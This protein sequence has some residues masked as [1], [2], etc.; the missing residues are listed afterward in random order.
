MLDSLPLWRTDTSYPANGDLSHPAGAE[1]TVVHRAGDDTYGFLHDS[2]IVVHK[3]VLFAAWY[4]CPSGEIVGESLIRG[5]RSVDGGRTWSDAEVIA[6]DHDREGVFY[7]PVQFLSTGDKLYAYV[8]TMTGHDVVATCEAFKLGPAGAPSDWTPCGTMAPLFLPNAGPART[9]DGTLLMAGRCAALLGELPTIP[10]VA[11]SLEPLGPWQ[12]IPLLPNGMLP[13]G[14]TL[15][16]PETTLIVNGSEV[17]AFVRNDYGYALVFTSRNSGRTWDGPFEQDMP[18]G[19]SR[20]C[21][22]V[23]STGQRYIIFNT[24]TDGYRDLLAIAVSKPGEREFSAV[25]KVAHGYSDALECGSEW[26][27]PAAVEHEGT[28]FVVYT[29]GKRHCAMATIPVASLV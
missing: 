28:L 27:Y 22:G 23:L 11:R 25:W 19:A 12:V 2:A 29:S 26:S 17:T 1:H 10:A 24:P 4:N 13:D 18:L 7:V 6:A 14:R 9:V 3:G 5:R 16:Y 20:M 8:S 21:S 15:K